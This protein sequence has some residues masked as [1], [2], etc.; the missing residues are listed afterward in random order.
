MARFAGNP[1]FD[2]LSVEAICPPVQSRLPGDTVAL[3]AVVIS[4]REFRP[5]VWILKE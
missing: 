5:G 3:N 1:Q 2:D 4:H